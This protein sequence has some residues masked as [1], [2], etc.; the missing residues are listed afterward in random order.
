MY[1]ASPEVFCD[2]N[3]QGYQPKRVVLEKEEKKSLVLENTAAQPFVAAG[4]KC[5]SID[6]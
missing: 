2:F 5:L 3:S 4:L 1:S 6:I